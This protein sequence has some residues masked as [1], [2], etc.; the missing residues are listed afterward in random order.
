MN[1]TLL[2]ALVACLIALV[3][4]VGTCR[5]NASERER[6]DNNQAVLFDTLR[7]YHV[8]DSL[9][10]AS[11]GTLQLQLS[12]FKEHRAADVALIRDLGLRLRR[13][14]AVAKTATV[15]TYN[16]KAELT[17]VRQPFDRSMRNDSV[18]QVASDKAS[19]SAL[20]KTEAQRFA[21]HTPYLD[22]DGTVE[23]DSLSAA[24]EIR[25]TL[26]QVLHR[27]PRFK[28]LGI[29]F[30]TKGVRQEIVSKNPHTRIVAA[31]YIEIKR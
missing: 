2:I 19:E 26:V 22:I 16:V 17:P 15:G 9:N 13:V 28:L 21:I 31:E 29:W 6:L 4:S 3:A 8:R 11:I 5:R 18:F 14:D 20:K 23:R 25:D 24:I 27:V 12:E 30:G 1:K 7:T 10:A